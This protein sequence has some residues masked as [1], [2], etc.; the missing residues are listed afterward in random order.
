MGRPTQERGAQPDR[1]RHRRRDRS[2]APQPRA[3]FEHYPRETTL[4]WTEVP[5]AV[6][7]WVEWDYK[8]GDTWASEERGTQGALIQAAQP[9]ATFKFIGAQPGRWR[10]WAVDATGQSGPKSQWREFTY[11]K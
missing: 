6:S 1:R 5:G 3:V 2:Q 10:V 4:V 8:C 11:T 7:H 9:V